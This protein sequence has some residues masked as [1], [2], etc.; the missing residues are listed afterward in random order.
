MNR[1]DSVLLLVGDPRD[2][3]FILDNLDLGLD[4]LTH[5][6]IREP[7]MGGAG[8]FRWRMPGGCIG[9]RDMPHAPGNLKAAFASLPVS[10]RFWHGHDMWTF[11]VGGSPYSP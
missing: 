3:R 5:K 1:L 7:F 9:G 6:S 8:T 10:G 4:D 11:D 2:R